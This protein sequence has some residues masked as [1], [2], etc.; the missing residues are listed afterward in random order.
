MA[1]SKTEQEQPQELSVKDLAKRLKTPPAELRKW[2]RS[3]GMGLGQRGKRY[4]FTPEQATAVARKFK[5]AQKDA[6]GK[7]GDEA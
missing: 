5:A 3:E 7:Q 2:L 6:Q 4:S 1:T